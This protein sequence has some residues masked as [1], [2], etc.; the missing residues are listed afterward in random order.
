M[1]GAQNTEMRPFAVKN[2]LV[3]GTDPE[4]GSLL[5]NVLKSG[6]WVVRTVRDNLAALAISRVRTFDLIV[7]SDKT[8]GR[9]DIELLRQIRL[10]HPH[11]RLIILTAESTPE[12]VIT[13]MR[14]RA[15][16]YFTRPF[17]LDTL[18]GMIRIATEG[19]CWDD[20]IEVVSGT[21][22]LIRILARCDVKT[23]DRLVQFL[24]EVAELPDPEKH[25]VAMAFREM[26]LNAIEHGGQLDP[27]KYVE[28]EYVR[29]RHMVTC[30]ITDPGPGFTLDEIPHAAIAN[31]ADDPVRHLALREE[32]G[33][34][35][36]GFG[37][38]LAQKLVDELIYGQDGNEV[39]L[40]KYLDSARPKS[41]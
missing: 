34:R 19:P 13:A 2:A 40:V 14:E 36:G 35:P 10:V 33:M 22:E 28:I 12:D 17:S 11:T 29:A 25:Q 30:H 6:S 27:N 8:S 16:S 4:I 23:A 5:L 41:A 38:L 32:Q 3:V 9:E 21:P 15:F 18:A 37:V 26:L 20:G 24:D 7:T 1:S 39:L 31:P